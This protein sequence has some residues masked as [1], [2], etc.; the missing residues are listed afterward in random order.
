VFIFKNLPNLKISSD[1]CIASSLVGTIITAST[2]PLHFNL[3]KI[4]RPNAAVLPVPVCACPTISLPSK[5]T[6]IACCWIGLGSL[7]PASS[8]ACWNS[9]LKLNSLKV[10]FYLCICLL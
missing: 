7:K 4:G 5:I 3:F 9:L 1:T 6:G 8:I 2:S 10:I